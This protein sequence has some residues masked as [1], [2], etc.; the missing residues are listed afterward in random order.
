MKNSVLLL[1]FLIFGKVSFAQK[2]NTFTVADRQYE[3]LHYKEAIFHYENGLK[4]DPQNTIA[5]KR[6]A[7]SYYQVND[8]EAAKRVY[9]ILSELGTDNGMASEDLLQYAEI[10][11]NTSDYRASK[12]AYEE[13][14]K[15]RKTDKRGERFAEAYD[16]VEHIAGKTAAWELEY[17]SINTGRAEYSPTYYKEG[18][19]F[20]SNREHG[21][22]KKRVFGWNNTPFVDMYY[23]PRK[24]IRPVDIDSL[25]N[26]PTYLKTVRNFIY[27]DDNTA[28]TS[29]DNS[30]VRYDAQYLNDTIGKYLSAIT[31]VERLKGKLNSKYHDGPVAVVNDSTLLLTRNNYYKK[32][33]RQSKNR[34]NKLKLY[35]GSR[36]EEDEWEV[37]ATLPFNTDEY[38]VGHPALSS[39]GQVLYFASD[40]PEGEGGVDLYKSVKNEDG[41]WTDPENLGAEI[42]TAGDEL[43][44]F[45]DARN[46]LYFASSGLPG[47]GGLDVFK[48]DLETLEKGNGIPENMG[49]PINSPQDDF[50][51]ILDESGLEGYLSSNR[52]GNDDI[53]GIV[54]RAIELIVDVAQSVDGIPVAHADIIVSDGTTQL[55]QQTTVDG[56]TVFTLRPD[57]EYKVSASKEGFVSVIHTVSTDQMKGGET[58][59]TS[60][61]LTTCLS[62][63]SLRSIYFD[64]DKYEV[65]N[66][67]RPALDEI[68]TLMAKEPHLK[69]QISSHTDPRGSRAYNE[70]LSKRRAEATLAYL[71]DQ[72]IEADRME[73]SFYGER[74][75][76]NRCADGVRCNEIQQQMNRRSD[77][78][79]INEELNLNSC[80]TMTSK[81]LPTKGAPKVKGTILS[82]N[83]R[84]PLKDI[85]VILIHNGEQLM[86]NTDERGSVSFDL[87]Y[88]TTYELIF[89]GTNYVTQRLYISTK[90][91]ATDRIFEYT[92]ALK[93]VALDERFQKRKTSN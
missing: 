19:L 52:R 90:G 74:Q 84:T 71:E 3:S 59:N 2:A 21:V 64:F 51:L 79:I 50:G 6:L 88:D 87:A 47:Y 5:L 40:I 53:Y 93:E 49:K 89:K 29:N 4:E 68:V 28:F 81:D 8:Y 80:S 34:V 70:L 10:L 62:D 7:D 9:T 41:S 11:A 46:H 72:G 65:R 13:F 85:Q 23:V 44:P 73:I 56:K 55:E 17:L 67:E 27:N 14:G 43:F 39:D 30:I 63:Y 1:A 37:T 45:I 12:K 58:L 76:T 92:I 82:E 61:E 77:I 38:S 69:I 33:Y 26:D 78:R 66:E 54:N 18:L 15:V 60:F 20:V 22:A 42:N 36:N 83:G 24:A 31:K 57:T 32:K 86:S 25:K 91:I 16:N 48:V 35:V 75:L